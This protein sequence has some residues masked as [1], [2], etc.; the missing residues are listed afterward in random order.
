M[1]NVNLFLA[2][3]FVLLLSCVVVVYRH[4]CIYVYIYDVTVLLLE[5][6]NKYS[7]VAWVQI[8]P[9]AVS[10][11]SPLFLSPIQWNPP[12]RISR[13]PWMFGKVTRILQP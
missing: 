13:K 8:Q 4:V 7:A 6:Q 9:T 11:H 3:A 10:A 1:H 5:K 12:T 2:G